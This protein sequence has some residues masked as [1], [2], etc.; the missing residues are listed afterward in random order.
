MRATSGLRVSEGGSRSA[1]GS[2][3]QLGAGLGGIAVHIGARIS[4]AASAGEVLVSQTVRDVVVG[5][6]LV[7]EDRGEHTLKGPGQWRRF[8]VGD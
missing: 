5:S 6:D 3:E 4:A 7:L 8:A 1:P 2:C